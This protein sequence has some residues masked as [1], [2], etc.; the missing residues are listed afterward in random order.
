MQ[1]QMPYYSMQMNPNNVNHTQH[2]G[3]SVVQSGAYEKEPPSHENIRVA[4]RIRP[5]LNFER[6]RG[7][8][9]C[10]E[11]INRNIISLTGKNNQ[12]TNFQFNTIL[13]ENANQEQVFDHTNVK[14]LLNSA[15]E[16]YS[17]SVLSYGQTG[18]GKTFT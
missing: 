10:L 15:L 13:P 5:L 3:Q 8:S 4:I 6:K 16:G 1:N 17:A 11:Q 14:T 7:D 9:R 18:S 12:Q 2:Y